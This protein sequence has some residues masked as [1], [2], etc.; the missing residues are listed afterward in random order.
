[1]NDGSSSAKMQDKKEL[2]LIKIVPDGSP[3]VS[4]LSLEEP[5]NA[6]AVGLKAAMDRS[7]TKAKLE[8]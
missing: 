7:F 6:N 1:M 4:I 3:K 2:Y 8:K 5:I